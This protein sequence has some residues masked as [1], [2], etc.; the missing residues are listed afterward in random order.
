MA[1]ARMSRVLA[2][3]WMLAAG[4]QTTQDRV[5]APA[6]MPALVR[7]VEPA[8]VVG[9]RIGSAERPLAVTDEPPGLWIR[10]VDVGQALCVIGVAASGHS[11]L[12]DAGHWNGGQCAKTMETMLPDAAGLSLIVL[13]HNDS[14]H[15]GDLPEILQ[16]DVDTI[17]WTGRVPPGCRRGAASGCPRT[18]QAAAK[19]VGNAA[20]RGT[21][22]INLKTTPLQSG[23]VFELGDV[24]IMFLAGW[25]EFPDVT[26]L[27]P[28][29]RENAISIM[30]RISYG[31]SSV[32]VTGDAIGR[33][34]DGADDACDASEAWAVQHLDPDWLSADVLIASHH[35]GDNGSAECFITAVAPEHVVFSAG[36]QHDHPRQSTA[37]RFMRLGVRAERM[38][39]TD[40]GSKSERDEWVDGLAAR[41]GDAGGDDDIDIVF[42][43]NES[44]DIGYASADHCRAL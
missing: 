36:A 38:L 10:V 44:L 20:R 9:A 24:E 26:G 16:R 19:A 27:S 7:S 41:C 39:R 29:E 13:T 21:T 11:F 42:T 33:P 15:L 25:N 12:I 28:A 4:C 3:V 34:L 6:A 23:Q 2:L 8:E 31:G 43:A 37:E 1:K 22:V 5:S 17:L 35:G 40:R 32:L 14:D 18:Y 30:T